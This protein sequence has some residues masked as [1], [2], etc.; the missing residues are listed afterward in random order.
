MI[1]LIIGHTKASSGAYNPEFDQTE[2]AFNEKLAQDI[3]EQVDLPCEIVY[4][5]TYQ[6]LPQKVN[7]LNP[8][9]C[10]SLH[11]NAFND[12]V[13]GCETLYYHN[14]EDSK[15][16]AKMM[17]EEIVNVLDI[18]DRGIKPKHAE[19]RGGY[20]LKYVEAP[21]ILTE[22]FFIDN[23]K[24][25]LRVKKFYNEFVQAHINAIHRFHNYL[26]VHP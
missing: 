22:P 12:Q 25:L 24:D 13:S 18:N 10:I 3:A 21:I 4:R 19:D 26:V 14:S 17:Q 11:C 20:I 6:G 5:E 2:F 9:F 16:F 1:A 23:N 15:E 7:D 8:L